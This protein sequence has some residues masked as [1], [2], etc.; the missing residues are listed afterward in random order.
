MV[1][2]RPEIDGLRTIA[3][4]PVILYHAG[5]QGFDG[6]YVGVDVFFVISGYLITT[7]ILREC[8]K[9]TF[10]ILN[11][12][13]RRARRILPALFF[14]VSVCFVLA[15]TF[16][17][18][19]D[20]RDFGKSVLATGLFGSNI[21]FWRESGYFATANE[22]KPLLHTWSLAAEEQYYVFF[23]I[24]FI[25]L[26]GAGLRRR[27]ILLV[28]FGAAIA[29][30]ILA[31]WG[32]SRYQSASFY[33]LPTRAW[34]LLVGAALALVLS[35]WHPSKG[36][37]TD[38]A[39]FL[40]L[41][42]II[43][44][45]T[46]LDETFFWPGRWA[47]LPVWG[48]ALI[49]LFARPFTLV[50]RGLA[51]APMVGIG[52]ISYSA[53]LWHQPLFAFARLASPTGHPGRI[54][55]AA[56]IAAAFV[57]AFLSWRYVE[58]PFR[59]SGI[60]SAKLVAV[61]AGT[62][63]AAMLVGGV[64]L[65]SADGWPNRFSP[66]VRALI[67]VA[68]EDGRGRNGCVARSDMSENGC[69]FP[70]PDSLEAP[71][72][73]LLWGDSHAMAIAEAL[74]AEL[75]AREVSL[76]TITSSGCAPI[77]QLNRTDRNCLSDNEAAAAYIEGDLSP[78]V[79]LMHGY[80]PV[81]VQGS[82]LVHPAEATIAATSFGLLDGAGKPV[83]VPQDMAAVLDLLESTIRRVS[84]A[85]KI[86]I[87]LG[88]VPEAGFHLPR[89]MA[90]RKI[91]GLETDVVASSEIAALR[92]EPTEALF[93]RLEAEGLIT[94]IRPSEL[95]CDAAMSRCTLHEGTAALYRDGNHLSR[96]GST[97]LARTVVPRIVAVAQN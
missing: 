4:L 93:L 9:G 57:L 56:L 20:L 63:T 53:Y 50:G 87:V 55:F 47:L 97:L 76:E 81:Y 79:V 40:G 77:L 24:V 89:Y 68:D 16:M 19:E 23:P 43:I 28:L 74:A 27:G 60:T 42:L 94:F 15:W 33:L 67:A 58:Q 83:N 75:A 36:W 66:D 41:G 54:A 62:G 64:V 13:E 52:L 65:Q 37:L 91:L 59:T 22:L 38:A 18:P 80:W 95:L 34:E 84:E 12:Y 7:I 90:R 44:A 3:V 35:R 21:L 73:M 1:G 49:I 46:F 17:F 39:A 82:N 48:T 29:G 26:W 31:D 10:S 88:S 70:L 32:S 2:Y 45:I 92:R 85:G 71:K 51:M 72:R 30:C 14:V 61:L 25:L 5:M 8:E 96:F 78:D 6:G 69:V 86:V 11:F